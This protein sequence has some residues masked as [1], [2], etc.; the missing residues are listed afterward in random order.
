MRRSV[1]VAVLSLAASLGV[2]GVVAAKPLDSSASCS[3]FLAAW[4][5]PNNGWIVQ[6]LMRPT[7][8][9]LDITVGDINSFFAHQH[10]GSLE[11]C[12]PA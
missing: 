7:A 12:I 10:E 6:N 2:A 4:A 9:D 8:E 1:S 3:G 11:A 5:N